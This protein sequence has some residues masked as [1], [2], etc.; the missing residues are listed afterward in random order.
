MIRT[1]FGLEQDPFHPSNVVMLAAQ[2]EILSTLRVHCQ[3][4]G[5]C[6]VLGAP[7][8][9]KSVIKQALKESD[10]KMLLTPTVNRTLHTYH[11]VLRI[12]CDAFRIEPEGL[13]HR[14]EAV[15]IA[16]AER[17]NK[18]GKMLA[19]IID[20]AHLMEVDSLRRLRLLFE[21]FPKNHNL[22]LIAQPELISK[23]NLAINDDLRSRVTYS[24]LL[25]KLAPDDATEFILAQLDKVAL[26]HNTFTDDA[27]GLIARSSEG[28]LRRIRNLCIASMMEAVRDRTKTVDL[29]QVNRV[30][31]QPHWR[32][33]RDMTD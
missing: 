21:D 19:P 31:L 18:Q 11:S 10:P 5:L 20:D 15:L 24:V 7:G 6:V 14:C 33:E 28:V 23:L 32:R 1:Y 12:L 8:T 27:L 30:L 3:Q 16:E 29:K 9:G 22:I 4:G 26:G 17:I 25:Q 13:A 2:D